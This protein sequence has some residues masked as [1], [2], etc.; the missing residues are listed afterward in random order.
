M[1]VATPDHLFS[2]DF[3]IT[4]GAQTVA[5]ID[6][7][8]WREKGVLSVQGANYRVYRRGGMR[9]G[10]VFELEGVE[11]ARAVKAGS[12]Y[13]SFTIDHEGKRYLLRAETVFGR[14]LVLLDGDE[15][16]GKLSPESV[17]NRRAI[18]D[19]PLVLPLALRVFIVWLSVILWRRKAAAVAAI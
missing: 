3:T 8:S 6:N 13:P 10:F 11:F 19:F 16:I 5:K 14:T 2:W 12:F 7:S 4:D 1:L 9:G 18:A 17:F 15:K